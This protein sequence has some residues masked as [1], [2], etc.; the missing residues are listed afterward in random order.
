MD[1]SLT[2]KFIWGAILICAVL[3]INPNTAQGA[4]I[5]SLSQK[6]A[7]LQIQINKLQQQLAGPQE[8]EL[9]Q[10]TEK[11]EL[12]EN[13]QNFYGN[14]VNTLRVF[15][16]TNFKETS[17]D[18]VTANKIYHASGIVIDKSNNPNRIYV[19]DTGNNRILGF[20]SLGT[21]SLNPDIK[22]TNDNDCPYS[23]ICEIDGNKSATLIFGQS[24]EKSAV[25]NG[26]NNLGINKNP[27]ANTLCLIRFPEATNIAE[28]WM[29][30]NF[31]VDDRG[32]LYAPDVHNNRIL[33]FN[34]PFSPDKSNG[35]G[36]TI[37]DF[38]WGQDDFDSNGTNRG[39]GENSRDNG[40]LFISF[41]GPGFDHVSSRG[42]SVDPSGNLWVADTFNRR[43]LRFSPNNSKKADLVLGQN[44]FTSS[45]GGCYANAPLNTMCTPTLARISPETGELYV[46]DERPYG[47]K[48]RILVFKPPFTNGMS[49]YKT[50]VPKQDGRFVND[51]GFDYY[52]QATGLTFNTYKK[53]EYASGTIWITEHQ[54]NRVILID[55]DGNIIKVIGAQD[56]YHKGCDYGY[57]NRCKGY[58]SIFHNFNLC[59]P[60]SSIG[61]DNANNIYLADEQ[62]HRI[63][64]FALPYEASAVDT[65]VCIPDANGGLFDG[66][67]P[68]S[69]SGYKFMGSVGTFVFGNQ[70]I[71][72]DL[73]RYLVWNNYLQKDIGAQADFVIGQNSENERVSN[74]FQ[75]GTRAFHTI[76]AKN[77][78]WTFNAHGQVIIYQLPFKEGDRPLANFVKLYW[79]DTGEEIQYRGIG[80]LAFDPINQKMWVNDNGNHRLLRISNYDN[81]NQS[82]YVDMVIGQPNKTSICCNQ[83]PK[84]EREECEW[85]WLASAPPRADTLC[86]PYQIKFDN[87]GNLYVV[88]NN[89]ECHGNNRIIVFMAEDI[90]NARGSFPN[91]NAKKVFVR[92]SL[93]ERPVCASNIINEPY[94]PVSIAFN[95]KNEMV[96]GNDG[97][98]GDSQQRHLKQIWFYKNPLKKKPDDSYIMGQK[99][100]AYVNIPIG[101]TGE[102]NFDGEDNLIIQDHTWCKV[103]LINLDK[104]PSWLI[105]IVK[106][107]ADDT[108][109]G[110]CSITN[111]KYCKEGVLIDKC[112]E[113]GCPTG[114]EC[115]ASGDCSLPTPKCS[116]SVQFD[117]NNDN[118]VTR[119]D[120]DLCKPCFGKSATSDC[121]KCNFKEE[122]ECV[123]NIFD[124]VEHQKHVQPAC[125]DD[126]PYGQC[127]ITNLKYC[128]NGTLVDKSSIC[129]CDPGMV[130]I[131][132][133]CYSCPS[134]LNYDLNDDSIIT[135]FDWTNVCNPCYLKMASSGGWENCRKCDFNGDCQITITDFGLF[136]QKLSKCSDGTLYGQCS[137]A[138]PKYCKEGVLV[139]KCSECGCSPDYNCQKDET[140]NI[141]AFPF[142]LG[143][144][145]LESIEN[146][147]ASI[148][149]ALFQILEQIKELISK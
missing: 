75:L 122:G 146:Q 56:K 97:Y 82:L 47:F 106:Y 66:T 127:S 110:Q 51:P 81:F 3:L 60:G 8:K 144:K 120:L 77:R 30:T 87:L 112:S 134:A 37:A 23:D 88:E 76:D 55:N 15:G 14:Y 28:Y 102:I 128:Q 96:I 19:A 49:A 111:P 2:R 104:D 105:P 140:C 64:R 20:D 38:V 90:R 39:L 80:G 142:P 35:K 44:D 61:I 32:N 86:D 136:S 68:N 12:R 89:Y 63:A 48:A 125:S 27:N 7:E 50:I 137:S 42:V 24:D 109:Y 41:G 21:C 59:W 130:G 117:Q 18:T 147:L 149:R 45:G 133:K 148:S 91:I 67:R 11:D 6:I 71:V 16:Q 92:K 100:D 107:C 74:E 129:G 95:S 139:D 33:K 10:Q 99:P 22:C 73:D 126:T 36:D 143:E 83:A 26:D 113:C 119:T 85:S 1:K 9:I 40:S 4:T 98:Y 93:T 94:S 25:C 141:S 108:P 101:A 132:D 124:T 5:E 62:F 70:L 69:V 118:I 115:Q 116:V 123:I 84:N 138:K 103:W 65:D 54:T 145:E 58:E 57:Y 46:I 31:D 135:P 131:S 29:R 79:D 34:E 114:Y 17:E 43:V 78:L 13:Q 52:F 53:G 121:E 72:K